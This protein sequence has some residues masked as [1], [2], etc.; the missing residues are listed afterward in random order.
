[1]KNAARIAKSN[2]CAPRKRASHSRPFLEHAIAAEAHYRDDGEAADHAGGK[3]HERALPEPERVA[4]GKL[5]RLAGNDHRHLLQNDQQAE[6]HGRERPQALHLLLHAMSV[7]QESQRVAA[8]QQRQHPDDAGECKQ[9]RRHGHAPLAQLPILR[10]CRFRHAAPFAVRIIVVRRRRTQ[11]R[12]RKRT[13]N[14][15]GSTPSP[16]IPDDW[17]SP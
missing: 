1:M 10:A 6:H 17:A 14:G 15:T 16:R 2:L 12:A 13:G 7:G 5:Q 4:R 11:V 3:V 9:R 8:E